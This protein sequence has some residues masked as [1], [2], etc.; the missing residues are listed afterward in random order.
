[1][2]ADRVDVDMENFSEILSDFEYD[3][4]VEGQGSIEDIDEM[5]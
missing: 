2:V 3:R 5:Y 4:D 1:M